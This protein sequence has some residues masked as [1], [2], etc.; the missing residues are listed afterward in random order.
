MRHG[1]GIIRLLNPDTNLSEEAEAFTRL[2]GDRLHPRLRVSTNR[3]DD[4]LAQPDAYDA[5]ISFLISPFPLRTFIYQPPADSQSYYLNGLL[6]EPQVDV[7]VSHETTTYSWARFITPANGRV[8]GQTALDVASSL[9][10]LNQLVSYYLSAGTGDTSLPATQLTLSNQDQVLLNLVHRTSDWVITFDHHLG[11]ELY[12]LPKDSDQLPFLL[13]YIPGERLLGMNTYLT[14]KPNEEVEHLIAPQL[15]RFY[16]NPE[17]N[18]NL[19]TELLEDL[20]TI[21]GTII[22]QLNSN[23]NRVLETI[24]IGLTK[25]FLAKKDVLESQILIPIDLHQYLFTDKAISDS[26]S[27]ADLLLVQ[28]IPAERRFHIQ[29]LE[30][31]SRTTGLGEDDQAELMREMTAQMD[32]TIRVWAAQFGADTERFDRSLKQKEMADMLRF[33]MLRAHRYGLLNEVERVAG[34]QFLNDLGVGYSFTFERKGLVFDFGNDTSFQT[35]QADEDLT[36][37]LIG[38]TGIQE[39]LNPQSDVNSRRPDKPTDDMAE[40]FTRRTRR[41]F[42]KEDLPAP[43]RRPVSNLLPAAYENLIPA[44][45]NK[46]LESLPAPLTLPTTIANEQPA[47]E[48][49]IV[50]Q[51]VASVS[52]SQMDTPPAFDLFIGDDEP[53]G[54]YGILG[55]TASRKTV[56]LSLSNT[57]TISLFG[58]QGAGKSYTLGVIAEMVL[59]PMAGINALTKPLAGII[60]HYSESQEYAPEFT[61]MNQPNTR[62]SE[63]QKLKTLY[64]ATADRIEDIILLV[65][66]AKLAER[67]AEYPNLQ[68][69]PLT[70]SSKELSIKDWLFL[71]G[72][73]D[74]QSL[75]MKQINNIMRTI[76]Q[77]ISLGLLEETITNTTSL[78]DSQKDQARSRLMLAHEYIDDNSRLGQLVKSGRLLI[79]DLRDEL[80][81]QD[82]ALG[83]FVI[84]LNIFANVRNE[85]GSVLSKFIVFDEAHKY[86]SNR[87]LTQN[88]VTAIREMRHKGVSLLI[89]SQ[90]PPSL[91]NEI[92]ELSSILVMH[93]FR[94]PQWLKHV[95]RSLEPTAHLTAKELSSLNAGEAY[96]WAA[97]SNAKSISQQPMKVTIRPRAT[98]HGGATIKAG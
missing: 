71:M 68:V 60:F 39:L 23:P 1:E 77:N 11:P 35:I 95:Q 96:V 46:V 31:K 36:F 97:K 69:L 10:T 38:Q 16:T 92:I 7:N 61:A 53:G 51:D 62:E 22:L 86:M 52:V 83:L 79:V 33:Y 25:R 43:M 45:D 15:N 57:N 18:T 58:V 80:I 17:T 63:L 41:S 91:P 49:A 13:D 32:N 5:H 73:S 14:T 84:M 48:Q 81:L 66:Q 27:R 70:F 78:N 65:P 76:R 2:T 34:I 24:G 74:N 87:Q 89:A 88:I 6:I 8:A 47:P 29:V 30:I 94:A 50:N 40:Q 82:E 19:A 28:M 3:V 55:Q 90:D 20:R 42:G 9:D 12:D 67:Q 59:K 26:K 21:S 85:D 75:Y 56:A 4:Y 37:F 72:A 44:A 54:Q 93:E 98:K 64:G